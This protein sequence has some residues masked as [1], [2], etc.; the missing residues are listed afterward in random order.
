VPDQDLLHV[1]EIPGDDAAQ[2][3]GIHL[4]PKGGRAGQVTEDERDRLPRLDLSF[5]LR[6]GRRERVPARL[7]EASGLRILLST[8]GALHL[9]EATTRPGHRSGPAEAGP[10]HETYL[11]Q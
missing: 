2:G 6:L 8:L 10:E 4:V 7:T 5:G 9:R 1:V 11:E 3:L